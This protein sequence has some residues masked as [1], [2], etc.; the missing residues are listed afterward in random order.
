[1]RAPRE[2]FGRQRCKHR[3]IVYNC[4]ERDSARESAVLSACWVGT[5]M[6]THV[7]RGGL[8]TGICPRLGRTR[9]WADKGLGGQGLGRTDFP[10]VI[11]GRRE[12]SS[13][14]SISPRVL[15]PDGFR[16]RDVVAP[17]NDGGK[18]AAPE[19]KP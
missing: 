19:P 3:A 10:P 5:T 13:P 14:Q 15:P 8:A 18:R 17:R 7:R 2:D 1:M 11:P 12:A 16:A 9:A 4:G 6:A